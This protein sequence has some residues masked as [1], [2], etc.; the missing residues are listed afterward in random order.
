[1]SNLPP[2]FP[3]VM[4]R[5]HGQDAFGPFFPDGASQNAHPTSMSNIAITRVCFVKLDL[6]KLVITE[7]ISSL[8]HSITFQLMPL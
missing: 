4:N 3:A 2:K 7:K 1:M 8:Q 6:T 5:D